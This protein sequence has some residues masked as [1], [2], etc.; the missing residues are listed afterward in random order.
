MC[1]IPHA[2]RRCYGQVRTPIQFLRPVLKMVE[3]EQKPSMRSSLLESACRR[4]VSATSYRPERPAKDQMSRCGVLERCILARSQGKSRNIT[5]FSTLLGICE[6]P[7]WVVQ[8]RIRLGRSSF[9]EEGGRV[10]PAG[11]RG[12]SGRFRGY[13]PRVELTS[14]NLSN[15]SFSV[16]MPSVGL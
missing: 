9:P 2:D 13:Q 15:T 4:S 16:R 5:L 7:S 11:Q 3:T 12:R 10:P 6:R 1:N 8:L 14:S